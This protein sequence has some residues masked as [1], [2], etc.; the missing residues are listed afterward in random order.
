MKLKSIPL[1]ADL[2]FETT[3]PPCIHVWLATCWIPLFQLATV[4]RMGCSAGKL[5]CI[6]TIRAI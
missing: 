1:K 5:V 6:S 3:A 4:L 2:M